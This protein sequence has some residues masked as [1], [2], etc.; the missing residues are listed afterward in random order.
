M[1]P[2]AL[3]FSLRLRLSILARYPGACSRSSESSPWRDGWESWKKFCPRCLGPGSNFVT[4]ILAGTF[5]ALN[6]F[7][8][9]IVNNLQSLTLEENN[10]I[11]EIRIYLV[12]LEERLNRLPRSDTAG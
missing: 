12:R 6:F 1:E 9:I 8:G 2:L 4:F 10:D 5:V 7:V 11:A 3:R